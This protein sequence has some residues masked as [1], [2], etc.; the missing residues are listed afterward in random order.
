MS[1]PL[2]HTGDQH[3]AALLPPILRSLDDLA[4]RAAHYASRLRMPDTDRETVQAAQQILEQAYADL[5]RL[6]SSRNDTNGA[7]E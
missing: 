2:Y 3:A 5:A 1:D 7:A 4:I 6:L